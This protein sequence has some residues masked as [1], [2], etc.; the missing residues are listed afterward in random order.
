MFDL[1]HTYQFLCDQLEDL[2]KPFTLEPGRFAYHLHCQAQRLEKGWATVPEIAQTLLILC[3][4][5]GAIK[6]KE[7]HY[8]R[9]I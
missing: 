6:L 7:E 3:E 5:V 9:T 4:S 2:L 1:H 8:V